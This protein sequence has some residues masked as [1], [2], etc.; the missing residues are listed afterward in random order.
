MNESETCHR[1]STSLWKNAHPG[2]SANL[3]KKEISEIHDKGEV[4][5]CTN[6]RKWRVCGAETT[7]NQSG[8]VGIKA[9]R[10]GCRR[11]SGSNPILRI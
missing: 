7:K 9:P 4:V 10:G 8:L 3:K 5:S 1:E 6:K 11:R 2:K